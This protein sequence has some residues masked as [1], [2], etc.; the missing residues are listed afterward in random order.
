MSLPKDGTQW[1]PKPV[2]QV[3]ARAREAQ[4]WW[5]GDPTKLDRYYQTNQKTAPSLT[6]R[7]KDAYRAFWGRPVGNTAQ[8][9]RRVHVPI[10]GG[11]VSMSATELFSEQWTFR[12]A[13][14]KVRTADLPTPAQP[15]AEDSEN[16][17]A[18]AS[19]TLVVPSPLQ[20]RADLILNSPQ[21]AASL[22]AAGVRTSALGGGYARVVFDPEVADNA[23][24]DYVDADHAFAE[25]RWGKVVAVTFWTELENLDNQLVLRH[26]ERHERGRIVHALYQG[27]GSNLGR[28]ID[29]GAHDATRR[30]KVEIGRDG[31]SYVATGADKELSAGYVPNVIPNPDWRNDPTLC[32]YGRSDLSVD[33]IPLLHEIDA[34]AS[35]LTR[36]F[37][38]SQA[39][40]YASRSVLQSGGFGEGLHLD[41]AQEMFTTIGDGMKDGDM[42][43]LFEYYQPDIRVE[44]HALG[45][46]VLTREVLRKTGYSPLT[47]GLPDEVAQ[48]ATEATGKAK[49]T[50]TTTQGKARLWAAMLA[51]IGTTCLRIDAAQ[52]PGKGVAPEEQ[53]DLEL[54]EF[55]SLS[56]EAKARVVQAWD[57]SGSASTRT[58]VAY[59]HSDWDEDRI[60]REA[61]EIDGRTAAPSPLPDGF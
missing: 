36:D 31:E 55:A 12:P 33:V 13:G 5:E 6:Q 26:L 15:Q 18:P 39:R 30:L 57:V 37:R 21:H 29:L 49:Q 45:I 61:Q 24:I 52:F 7:A 41:D 19:P 27:T 9:I 32:N 46:E 8:P 17:T 1:P 25:F 56:D 28:R 2:A 43:S 50:L 54:P 48:T 51:P 59:L 38:V 20:A 3:T 23:W 44:K 53:L 11:I 35:G 47:F 34:V 10:A 60:D 58:K 22:F 16:Q 4:V 14:S 40:V 42:A